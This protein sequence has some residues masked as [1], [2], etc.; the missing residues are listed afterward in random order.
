MNC[1]YFDLPHPYQYSKREGK[2][3]VASASAQ[4]EM[5]QD[6]TN[7]REDSWWSWKH[8]NYY[9]ASDLSF[10]S[11]ESYL[12]INKYPGLIQLAYTMAKKSSPFIDTIQSRLSSPSSSSHHHGDHNDHDDNDDDTKEKKSKVTDAIQFG[13]IL[14]GLS[15]TME[16]LKSALIDT[17]IAND[18]ITY[19]VALDWSSKDST[20]YFGA[21]ETPEV[22]ASAVVYPFGLDLSI[23]HA[24]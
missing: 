23:N 13:I 19:E 18:M 22:F 12:I 5:E 2:L 11:F 9:L 21:K 1:Y 24:R 15:S 14:N 20:G 4:G 6:D 10:S 16:I 3:M 7:N 17:G 8:W